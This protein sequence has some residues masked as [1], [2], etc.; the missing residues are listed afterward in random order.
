MAKKKA[1]KK[2]TARKTTHKEV[3]KNVSR[4]A[5]QRK[6]DL[7]TFS[8]AQLSAALKTKRSGMIVNLQAKRRKLMQKVNELDRQIESAGGSA[9][10]PTSRSHAAGSARRGP[11]A[12][13]GKLA[14][15]VLMELR[16]ET[17]PKE[18]LNKVGHL[19]GGKN[20][21]AIISQKLMALRAQGSIRNVSRGVWKV[22]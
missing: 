9:S 8:E 4:K 2:A 1:S 14:A 11:K 12:G 3:A 15:A 21:A 7:A 13:S 16:R 22:E 20:K 19:I 6:I 10:R 17:T 5:T 18:L